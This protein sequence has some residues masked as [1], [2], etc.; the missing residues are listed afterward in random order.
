MKS[1][2]GPQKKEKRSLNIISV[3]GK[4][5]LKLCLDSLFFAGLFHYLT[6]FCYYLWTLLYFLGLFM[7]FTVLF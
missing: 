5:T 1:T 6:Y 7:S 3:L 2:V 4:R